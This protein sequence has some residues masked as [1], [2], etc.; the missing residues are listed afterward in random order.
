MCFFSFLNA[1]ERTCR[2]TRAQHRNMFARRTRPEWLYQ[3]TG[4][5]TAWDSPASSPSTPSPIYVYAGW[6]PTPPPGTPPDTYTMLSSA[7]STP[8][9]YASVVQPM[10]EPMLES[11]FANSI[12]KERIILQFDSACSEIDKMLH[13]AM[14]LFSDLMQSNIV[15]RK[16]PEVKHSAFAWAQNWLNCLL[17]REISHTEVYLWAAFL[18]HNN[19][20][21]WPR[22]NCNSRFSICPPALGNR[23]IWVEFEEYLKIADEEWMKRYQERFPRTKIDLAFVRIFA[24]FWM[25]EELHFGH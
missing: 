24:R 18:K 17:D 11:D 19:H 16:D 14:S 5:S 4:E 23:A 22:V 2:K 13:S 8:S 9:S 6:C 21:D 20:F 7:H 1:I 10:N 3:Q 15:I 12:M 25:T